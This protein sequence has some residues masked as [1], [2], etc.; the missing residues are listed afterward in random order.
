MKGNIKMDFSRN[1][2][3]S[4]V[5]MKDHK[6]L[7]VKHTYGAAKGL[8]LI[9]GGFCEK[10][11]MPDKAAERE[12]FEET[13]VVVKAK[14]LL[15]VRFTATEI[16]CIFGAEYVSGIP[17]SDQMENSEALFVDLAEAMVSERVVAT[18]RKILQEVVGQAKKALYKSDFVNQKFNSDSRQL[19]I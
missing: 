2:S 15:A 16:W 10:E 13:K 17:K 6:V 1:L 7:L 14:E 9:P 8:F 12:V 5:V 18:T 4:C 3:A 19:Y 11:E